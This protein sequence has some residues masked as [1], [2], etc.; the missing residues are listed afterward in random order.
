VKRGI[1]LA[2]V[3]LA[4]LVITTLSDCQEPVT[5]PAGSDNAGLPEAHF[6]TR[7]TTTR[8]TTCTEKNGKPCP[9]WL[10]KLIGEYPPPPKSGTSRPER[11][12]LDVVKRIRSKA[13]GPPD[14]PR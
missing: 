14:A 6:V 4:F 2:L 12:P 9:E 8:A 3:P 7:A 13:Q 10:H 5:P 11:N 1:L